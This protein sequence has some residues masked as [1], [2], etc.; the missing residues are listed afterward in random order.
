MPS[1]EPQE[2]QPI[3]I[4]LLFTPKPKDMDGDEE[5]VDGGAGGESSSSSS[6]GC[7]DTSSESAGGSPVPDAPQR[8]TDDDRGVRAA[9]LEVLR[10]AGSLQKAKK[11][12]RFRSTLRE[13]GNSSLTPERQD[14]AGGVFGGGLAAPVQ[15]GVRGY[16]LEGA[17]DG[18]EE[19]LGGLVEKW[20][21]ELDR[22]ALGAADKTAAAPSDANLEL[23]TSWTNDMDEHNI[24]RFDVAQG[25][26]GEVYERALREI[27]AGGKKTHWMWFMFPQLAGAGGVD[28]RFCTLRARFY[29]VRS[30]A[31]ARAL[32]DHPRLG[33]R[34]RR[35]AAAVL[36]AAP[37][38]GN[39]A[40]TLMGGEVDAAKLRSSM[41][42]FATATEETTVFRQV[43]DV[44]FGGMQD[45]FTV[46][47]LSKEL[48]GSG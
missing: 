33:W 37:A 7:H 39:C 24:H 15:A 8:I 40:E 2:R 43:L 34:L 1:D 4:K 21:D 41:T 36:A 13:A 23:S 11:I 14:I 44:M 27:L 48:E 38:V 47:L 28:P 6:S 12:V 20:K 17:P 30:L 18:Y 9:R 42:L 32:L 5:M 22:M 19:S 16:G 46:Q 35:M 31:E 45:G 29:H 26:N 25:R 3:R 10:E